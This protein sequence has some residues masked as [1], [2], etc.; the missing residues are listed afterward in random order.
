[1]QLL[2]VKNILIKKNKSTK[3]ECQGHLAIKKLFKKF[4]D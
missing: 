2:F 1:M 3:I 4:F